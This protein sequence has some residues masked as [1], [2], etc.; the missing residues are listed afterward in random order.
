MESRNE[1]VC[2]LSLQGVVFCSPKDFGRILSKIVSV[3]SALQKHRW[4]LQIHRPGFEQSF[5]VLH[6]TFTTC[7]ASE[8][9]NVSETF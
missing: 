3:D 7:L 6:G 8:T 5:S 2:Q 9:N 4:K 1:F